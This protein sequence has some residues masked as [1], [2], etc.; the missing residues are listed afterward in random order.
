MA[1]PQTVNGLWRIH[2]YEPEDSTPARIN[3][4]IISLVRNDE[5][6]GI[7]ASM[8][9]VEAAWN[10][11]FDY[12]WIFF[13]DVPFTDEFKRRTQA[14]TKLECRYGAYMIA[15][16]THGRQEGSCEDAD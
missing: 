1:E 7:V 3:A 10:S 9:Q 11:K 8:R 6:E 13:N 4:S 14:E 5:L 2:E 12:P 16:V 15:F